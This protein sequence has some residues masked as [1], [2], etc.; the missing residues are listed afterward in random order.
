M[1]TKVIS[2]ADKGIPAEQ[3]KSGEVGTI[4]QPDRLRG[5]VVQ[6]YE[7]HLVMVGEGDGW[8]GY[9]DGDGSGSILVDIL[10]T[11]TVLKLT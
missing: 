3:M 5:V 10:P 7:S 11:G 1:G 6:R 4:T 9:F 8:Y 2:K